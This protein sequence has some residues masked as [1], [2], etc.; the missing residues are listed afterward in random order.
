MESRRD[1]ASPDLGRASRHYLLL[2]LFLAGA[3]N[4]RID[5]A[6]AS[7]ARQHRKIRPRE[8]QCCNCG[9]GR[10]RTQIM[11]RAPGLFFA[12]CFFLAAGETAVAQTATD[13]RA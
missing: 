4:R 3:A 9:G 10:M 6:A 1:L 2:R 7:L 12:L 5:R 11:Q 13:A 8:Q